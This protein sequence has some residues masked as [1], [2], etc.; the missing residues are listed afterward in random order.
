MI[1]AKIKPDW[2]RA[3]PE[4]VIRSYNARAS[5]AGTTAL[6]K[7]LMPRSLDLNFSLKY[8]R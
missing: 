1:N 7:A 2:Q 3:N 6:K 5:N 4:M 8:R